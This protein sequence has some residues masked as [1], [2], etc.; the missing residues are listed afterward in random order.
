MKKSQ[1]YVSTICPNLFMSENKELH[2]LIY[3][4]SQTEVYGTEANWYK[5]G[6]QI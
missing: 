1:A 6:P 5:D 4:F 2:G 3:S